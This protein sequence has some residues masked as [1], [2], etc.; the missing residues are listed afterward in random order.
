M[1]AKKPTL[2]DVGRLAGVSRATAS[3]VITSS[4]SVS[5]PSAVRVWR[6][7]ELLGYEPDLA[8]R[9]LAK[10][11]S[12]IVDLIVIDENPSA[13]GTNP[14]YS[15]VVAGILE[16]LTDTDAQ[17]RVHVV[18][19]PDAPSLI[20]HVA[21]TT[22]IGA[23]LVNVP[24]LMAARFH[25]RNPRVVSLGLT[26]PGIASIEARNAEGARDAVRHLIVTGRKRIAAVHGPHYNSCARG[27]KRGFR[28]AVAEAG[29][30]LFEVEGDFCRHVG[31]AAARQLLAAH[32]D[33]DAIFAA[34][35][36]TATGVLEV[37]GDHGRR[38]PDDVALVGFDDSVLA[39]C[40]TPQLTSV[41]QP[42]E[43]IAAT[44]TRA[45]LT[46]EI[47]AARD[48]QRIV[49]TSLTVRRSTAA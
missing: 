40:A 7:V 41:R 46:G 45:L 18:D 3:R 9:A 24:P 13:L 30:P 15:R 35:D 38:V 43:Q 34:C 21:R 1:E 36:L 32:P 14:Y 4:R 27:R 29:V 5:G 39:R 2:E 11:R 42:V 10:G 28:E 8:A 31:I 20:D 25:A 19:E 48:W 44:A 16:A 49:A 12:N 23:L 33:V 22:G 6:A 17:M 37:L 26:A 47:G